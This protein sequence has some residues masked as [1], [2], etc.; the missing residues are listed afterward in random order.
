MEA[1]L[2]RTFPLERNLP[3]LHLSPPF[4]FSP[5]V[6]DHTP[7]TFKLRVEVED[8]V[9]VAGLKARSK[10]GWWEI[11]VLADCQGREQEVLTL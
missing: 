2:K 9:I 10:P 1:E 11:S 7:V 6:A 3:D 4:P 8:I 5:C